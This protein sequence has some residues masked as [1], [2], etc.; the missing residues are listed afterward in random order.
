MSQYI[1]T[2]EVLPDNAATRL[3]LPAPSSYTW[4]MYA[5]G[6]TERDKLSFN[7][8]AGITATIKTLMRRASSTTRDAYRNW[9]KG[10]R[11]IKKQGELTGAA[12]RAL[13]GADE[14]TQTRNYNAGIN[15][16]PDDFCQWLFAKLLPDKKT[17]TVD[18]TL[19]V[20]SI[21]FTLTYLLIK[22][23]PDMFTSNELV[24]GGFV[25]SSLKAVLL[26]TQPDP[27]LTPNDLVALAFAAEIEEE[28]M[29]VPA[30]LAAAADES[31]T[32]GEPTSTRPAAATAADASKAAAQSEF[33][34]MLDREHESSAAESR[35]DMSQ[36]MRLLASRQARLTVEAKAGK[37]PEGKVRYSAAVVAQ[38]I[39]FVLERIADRLQMTSIYRERQN[40][41]GMHMWL[42]ITGNAPANA[43]A[44]ETYRSIMEELLKIGNLTESVL[45]TYGGT[46]T[47]PATVTNLSDLTLTLKV[48]RDTLAKAHDGTIKVPAPEVRSA[49][50]A[51]RSMAATDGTPSVFA[52]IKRVELTNPLVFRPNETGQ[53]AFFSMIKSEWSRAIE[54]SAATW[55]ALLNP[56]AGMRLLTSA[57]AGEHGHTTTITDLRLREENILAL[58]SRPA[59]IARFAG[60]TYDYV[61]KITRNPVNNDAT[62]VVAL[63]HE[64]A[65][66]GL[67]AREKIDVHNNATTK[68]ERTLYLTDARRALALGEYNWS[69]S[70]SWPSSDVIHEAL[71]DG[72]TWVA[73]SAAFSR[74][75]H[76][77]AALRETISTENGKRT[78]TLLLDLNQK[79]TDR[80]EPR[81]TLVTTLDEYGR[82]RNVAVWLYSEAAQAL[83]TAATD[84]ADVRMTLAPILKALLQKSANKPEAESLVI[85]MAGATRILQTTVGRATVHRVWFN[86]EFQYARLFG[87]VTPKDAS[88]IND[89]DP[90]IFRHLA[91]LADT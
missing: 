57:R 58:C 17:P 29:K 77:T 19:Y 24:A 11:F 79:T 87:L 54:I 31:A 78:T 37:K 81:S 26:V 42:C 60:N 72:R 16:T 41:A 73:V 25:D 13:R 35:G 74:Y 46:E 59:H 1:S 70:G 44:N 55:A 23:C 18:E 52:L 47:R 36:Q 51:T 45:E 83:L 33:D 21:F 63:R 49:L 6:N 84:V 91:I 71:V 50:H 56:A 64:E 28:L 82:Q 66:Y 38:H 22:R 90:N 62:Q 76:T 27:F 69:G 3:S 61:F 65:C 80:L 7:S 10:G 14:Q 68:Y 5:H 30:L 48:V 75:V 8:L 4:F 89:L 32:K 86:L 53:T 20:L 40:V 67:T 15:D 85:D 39:R 34:K 12:V 43:L 2:D 88:F 9:M